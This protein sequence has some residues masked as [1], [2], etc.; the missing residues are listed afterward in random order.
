MIQITSSICSVV[1]V[2]VSEVIQRGSHLGDSK[3]PTLCAGPQKLNSFKV[4]N[5]IFSPK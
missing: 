5:L 1:P 4:K 2:I 3:N